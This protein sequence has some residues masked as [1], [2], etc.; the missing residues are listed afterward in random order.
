MPGKDRTIFP[1]VVCSGLLLAALLATLAYERAEAQVLYGSIVGNVTDPSDAPVPGATVTVTHIA[2]GAIRT[3]TT[4]VAGGYS[5]PTLTTGTYEVKVTKEGFQAFTQSEVAVTINTVTRVDVALR[6][7][8]VTETVTVAAGAALLQTDR[9]EVRAEVSSQTLENLPVPPG[10]NYQHLLTT[11][12][13]FAQP[14]NA[15]SVPSNPSRALQYEV[16]G[17]VAASNNVRLDGATQYNVW[18]PH[19]TAYTPALESIE[20]INIVTNS[21]DAEQGLAGGAAINVQVKSGT[22]DFRGSAFWYHNNN[23]TKAKPFFTPPGERNPKDIFNQ[24]GGTLGGPIVR[25]KLFFF[26]S[27]EGTLIRQFASGLYTLPTELT[28]RGIMTESDRAVYDPATGNPDGTGRTPFADNTI[29]PARFEPIVVKLVNMTPKPTYTD[30]F[31]SN[32]YGAGVWP[33]DRHTLDTKINWHASDKLNMYGRYSYLNFDQFVERA[34]GDL[35]GP[36]VTRVFNNPGKGYGSTHSVTAALTYVFSPT[37]LLDANFGLTQMNTSAVQAEIDKKYGLDFLGIPGT[38]GTRWFEGGWPRFVVGGH[39]TIGETET[40]MPYRRRDPQFNYQ[41]N[42]NWLR[43]SHD[44]RFGMDLTYQQLN[45][46]QPEFYGGTQGGAGGFTFSTT[47]ATLRGGPAGNQWNAYASFLLGLPSSIGKIIQFPDE[48]GTRTSMYSFYV[49][50]RW[51]VSRKLTFSF[52]TRWEYFPIPTRPDRGLERY[53]MGTNKMHVCGVGV[54]PRDCG[55]QV[56][57]RLFAPRVGL[58]YRATET[59]VIRAGYGITT[60]PWSLARPM[61]ANHP[62]LQ[63]LTIDGAHSWA[64][65]GLLRNGIPAVRQPDLGNGIIDIPGTVD[66]NTLPAKFKRGYIQSWNL[67]LQKKL[68]SLTAQAGYVATRQNHI[69]GFREQNYG[70]PG[71]GRASQSYFQRFGRAASTA[72]V[73]PVGNSHYDALQTSLERRFAGGYHL[74][75]AYTWSKCTGIAG[76]ANSGDRPSIHIPEYF[77][78]NRAL[79]FMDSPHNLQSTVIVELPFGRGKRWAADGAVAAMLGGWQASAVFSSYSGYPFS[80]VSGGGPLNAPYNSQRADVI[81]AQPKKLGGVGPGQAFYDWTAFAPVTEARFGTAA[82]NLLRGPGLINLD[83][84]LFRQFRL[85]EK[86]SLQFRAEAFNSTNT[87]HFANPS[88]NIDGLRLFADGTFRSGVFEVTGLRNT[89]REGVDERV[90]RFGL[91]LSF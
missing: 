35:A 72:L 5:F 9:A 39:S 50:D 22:N 26:A 45:H 49:R 38:N 88:N 34:F 14:R 47:M 16:N 3:A 24:F 87:P 28:R 46:T 77:H 51:Q 8:A 37:L 91:R 75:I 64:P 27:H 73:G 20:T 62:M 83:L 25:H 82:F 71:G 60:D 30:R 18:L 40:Y 12:P 17:T 6:V 32:F 48:Y 70:L 21:F 13:G 79:C 23:K 15:H 19:I 76:V 90:F 54:V 89:G 11:I 86:V 2:T 29:P 68:G 81:K 55:V 57:K 1:R 44:L 74:N 33:F 61:R 67:M 59:F 56:S 84:G 63:S 10:R 78:L 43:G 36:M 69:M 4:G 58:A 53:D 41:A 80:V 52:G 65:A 66:A 7:G 31:T 85:T 42:L